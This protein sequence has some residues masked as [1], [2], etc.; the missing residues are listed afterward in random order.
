MLGT[1]Q[2]SWA[3]LRVPAHAVHYTALSCE[4]AHMSGWVQHPALEGF[5]LRSASRLCQDVTTNVQCFTQLN[6]ARWHLLLVTKK[7]FFGIKTPYYL[8]HDNMK[9]FLHTDITWIIWSAVFCLLKWCY[10]C[11]Q[12][13]SHSH[14]KWAQ[15]LA[16]EVTVLSSL[17]S[18]VRPLTVSI[19]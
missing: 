13:L 1:L 18:Q 19:F 10:M 3:Q 7:M 11:I 14:S 8:E 6:T 15:R 12:R 4:S 2:C 17:S 5:A 9:L 16:R